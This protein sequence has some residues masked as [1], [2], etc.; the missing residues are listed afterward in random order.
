MPKSWDLLACYLPVVCLLGAVTALLPPYRPI[1]A[2]ILT[3]D[4]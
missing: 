3:D 1:I 2:A 4:K